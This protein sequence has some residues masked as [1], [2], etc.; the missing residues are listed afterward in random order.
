MVIFTH[1]LNTDTYCLGKWRPLTPTDVR[2]RDTHFYKFPEIIVLPRAS[3]SRTARG[4]SQIGN[5]T[6]VWAKHTQTHPCLYQQ[7]VC[8]SGEC[9]LVFNMTGRQEPSRAKQRTS[10]ATIVGDARVQ[11]M[12]FTLTQEYCIVHL[13]PVLLWE[14]CGS[15]FIYVHTISE[16]RVT[17]AH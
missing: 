9:A 8:P 16:H 5:H 11:V 12:H 14:M 13:L 7:H 17:V 1:S 10:S 4:L 6:L 3:C 15:H 2:V